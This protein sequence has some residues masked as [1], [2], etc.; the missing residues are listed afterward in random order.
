MRMYPL[1]ISE[2]ISSQFKTTAISG[3]NENPKYNRHDKKIPKK[4][5]C[6]TKI[7]IF[8]EHFMLFVKWEDFIEIA[9]LLYSCSLSR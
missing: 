7:I 2:L 5:C 3:F 8:A 9:F 4:I 1:T 6:V